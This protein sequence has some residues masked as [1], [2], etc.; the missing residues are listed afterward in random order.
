MSEYRRAYQEGGCCFFTVVTYERR[1][2]LEYGEN[3]QRLKKAFRHVMQNYPFT[4][5]S[6]VVLPDHLHCIWLLP[7]GDFDFSPRWR[8]IKRYF[9]IG[10]RAPINHRGEKTVWQRRFWEH[11]IRSEDDWRKHVD[12]IH[13]NPVK[14]GYVPR[15]A[16]WP[17]SSF[18]QAVDRGWYAVDWGEQE[19]DNIKGLDF[20]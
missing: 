14:H 11:L 19:P 5:D 15:P 6:V 18:Q 10:I 12:Y 2:I 7:E 3:I 8:L 13:Y 16:D 4:M 20:E 1:R 9:S 17:Y